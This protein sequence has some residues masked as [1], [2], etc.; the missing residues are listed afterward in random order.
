MK[1]SIIKQ[2]KLEESPEVLQQA[3]KN[4][5]EN[6]D[7]KLLS[8]EKVT[9]YPYKDKERESVS[10]K[11]YLRYGNLMVLLVK[12]DYFDHIQEDSMIAGDIKR[13]LGYWND[14]VEGKETQQ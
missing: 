9:S 4:R 6:E 14:F 10:F 12:R 7:F 5:Q 8:I 3:I 13:M 1:L 2:I 11:A